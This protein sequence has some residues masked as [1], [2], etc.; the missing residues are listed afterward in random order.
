M[1][2]TTSQ[3]TE[4]QPQA[5]RPAAPPP[6]ADAGRRST[7]VGATTP[8]SS[9][10]K[11]VLPIVALLVLAGLGWAFK[12]WS[13]GRSHESTDNAQVDGHIVPVLAKVGG[14]VKTVN[15]DENSVV[16]EGQTIVQIDDAEY[17]V[18]LAQAEADLAAA[19]AAVGTGRGVGQ[20]EA[21]VQTAAGQRSVLEA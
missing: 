18:R 8:P 17:R 9:R 5:T 7:A 10:R 3:D 14:Y 6:S 15:A 2:T 20:A 16:K 13:Y 19:Q 21:A 11:F 4:A 1:A 12:Q